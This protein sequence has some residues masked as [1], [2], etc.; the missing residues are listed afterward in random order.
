MILYLRKMK[1]SDVLG[2]KVADVFFLF[3]TPALVQLHFYPEQN[4]KE[5][6]PEDQERSGR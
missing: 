1:V 3:P 4:P 6:K 2:D 5:N